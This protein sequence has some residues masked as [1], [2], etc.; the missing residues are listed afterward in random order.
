MIFGLHLVLGV[1]LAVAAASEEEVS[2]AWGA[3]SLSPDGDKLA[4]AYYDG[5]LAFVEL[6][7][8]QVRLRLPASGSRVRSTA[9]TADG[10]HLAALD[11]AGMV[12]VVDRGDGAM[13][14]S[15][16]TTD[17]YLARPMG[18][19]SVE[20]VGDGETL[21]VAC[22]SSP[23]QLWRWRSAELV[24]DLH[25]EGGPG[26]SH[27]VSRDRSFVALGDLVGNVA[28]WDAQSGE[29]VA[30]PVHVGGRVAS[31]AFH[32]DG[33]R[34]AVGTEH[35]MVLFFD[36]PG[37]E[38]S[39]ELEHDACSFF[40]KDYNVGSVVFSSD[41]RRLLTG[42]C[43]SWAVCAWDLESGRR[44]WCHDYGGG[45]PGCVGGRF[46]LDG[47]RVTLVNEGLVLESATGR[48]L[49]TLPPKARKERAA[50]PWFRGPGRVDLDRLR[51]ST[52]GVADFGRGDGPR[53]RA[54]RARG[55]VTRSAAR[56]VV[57]AA[58]W[59][60]ERGSVKALLRGESAPAPWRRG[61]AEQDPRALDT[62]EP[63]VFPLTTDDQGGSP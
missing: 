51:G 46:S 6:E 2:P 39:G 23:A 52:G 18:G 3:C 47:L 7:R 5:S 19:R 57:L 25:L 34:L 48:E 27:C 53:P 56:R 12:R 61:A 38:A 14:G 41:G 22:G 17:V 8:R 11:G 13:V 16:A 58:C 49:H 40:G 28:V 42:S 43:G 4:L 33:T 31:L 62:L 50:Q 15:V 35:S 55:E 37:L 21:L 45:N 44:L 32:P 29:P 36:L 26:Y 54:R 24:A 1:A 63:L 30:E 9:W 60:V 59:A 20:F 10:R